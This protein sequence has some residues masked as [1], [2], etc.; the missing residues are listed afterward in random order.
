MVVFL[1]W[2]VACCVLNEY[3]SFVVGVEVEVDAGWWWG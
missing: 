1:V 3:F 2:D